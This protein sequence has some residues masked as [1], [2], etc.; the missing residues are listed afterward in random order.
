MLPNLGHSTANNFHCSFFLQAKPEK[1]VR[2][3]LSQP[4]KE[5]EITS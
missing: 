1:G 4:E 2:N 3:F 5:G